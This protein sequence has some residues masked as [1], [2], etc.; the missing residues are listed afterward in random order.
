M[1][2]LIS[3]FYLFFL[4]FSLLAQNTQEKGTVFLGVGIGKSWSFSPTINFN[5]TVKSKSNLRDGFFAPQWAAKFG[6]V[7]ANHFAFELNAERFDWYYDDLNS[8]SNEILYTR[9]GVF[10]MDKIFKTSKSKFAISWFLGFSGG[11]VFSNNS[12]NKNLIRFKK[13]DF[14]GFGA[15]TMLGLRF[16]FYKRFYLLLK[17]PGR[18]IYQS[19]KGENIS[20]NLTQPYSS[21]SISFGVFLYERWDESCNTCPKW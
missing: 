17:Q 10:G 2:Y 8:F 14:N 16:E 3:L 15:T 4:T 19:V 18:V 21:T 9:I 1:K 11:P 7:F 12:W 5:Y 13:N 6:Y 20:L